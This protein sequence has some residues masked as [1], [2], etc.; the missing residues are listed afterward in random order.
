MSNAKTP[1]KTK[2]TSRFQGTTIINGFQVLGDANLGYLPFDM[3]KF[4]Y[5]FFESQ[6]DP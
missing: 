1:P 5:V 3:G 6:K 4:H 2:F